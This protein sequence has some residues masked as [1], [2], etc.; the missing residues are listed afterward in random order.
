[1]FFGGF[2]VLIDGVEVVLDVGSTKMNFVWLF[3]KL[4]LNILTGK[5]V[6]SSE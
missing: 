1:M 2:C 6:M 3:G 5:E 4:V